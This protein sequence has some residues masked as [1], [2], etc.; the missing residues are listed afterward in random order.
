M[1]CQILSFF[2]LPTALALSSNNRAIIRSPLKNYFNLCRGLAALP[3]FWASSYLCLTL[4][5]R[6]SGGVVEAGADYQKNLSEEVTK[7][8][9]LYGGGDLTKFPDFKFTG[10]FC[11]L[12]CVEWS[13]N[14]WLCYCSLV[15][16]TMLKT[17]DKLMD[18]TDKLTVCSRNFVVD[19]PQ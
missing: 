16:F 12:F 15:L 17:V 6:A 8:Q 3:F 4:S 7:L 13:S 18:K 9:R 11:L 2:Y 5:S 19:L 14:F 10:E 1:L